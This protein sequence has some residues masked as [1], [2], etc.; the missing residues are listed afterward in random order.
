MTNITGIVDDCYSS[1]IRVGSQEVGGLAAIIESRIEELYFPD[2]DLNL[3][4]HLCISLYWL[5][6]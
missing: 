2:L 4:L 5:K 1:N 6:L 3:T